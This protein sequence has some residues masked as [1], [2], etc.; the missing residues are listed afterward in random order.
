MMNIDEQVLNSLKN[1]SLINTDIEHT[2]INHDTQNAQEHSPWFIQVF[3]GISGFLASLFFIG[4][5]TLLLQNIGVLDSAMAN[6]VIGMVLIIAGFILFKHKRLRR[7]MFANSLAFTIGMAGQSYM[8][9]ALISSDVQEPFGVWLFLWFQSIMTFIMPNFI[10]RIMSSLIAF[11][12][13]VYLLNYYHLP[14]TVL[15]LLALIVVITNLQRY[16]ILQLVSIKWRATT[17]DAIKAIGYASAL[18][19]LCVSVYFIAAEHGD[20]FDNYNAVFRYNYYVAQGLLTLA[21]MYGD[22]VILRRYQ[23]KLL[24][25]TGIIIGCTVAIIGV[26]SIYVSG[27][28]ATSLVILIAVANSQRLLLGLGIAA[29]VSYIFWY[30]YQLDT[31]LLVKSASMFVVGIA[32]FIVRWLVIKRYFSNTKISANDNQERLS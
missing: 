17:F 24:S 22:A 7:R 10:F 19:L 32:L 9:Y 8:A 4:F 5:L 21:S 26:M 29:L 23:I 3:F 6:F 13:M 2:S 1:L 18:M 11:G 25:S 27:L 14:E 31:S 30:Y 16:R 12:C 28:L 15:G 20:S